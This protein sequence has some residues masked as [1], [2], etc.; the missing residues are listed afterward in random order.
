MKRR[1]VLFIRLS[2]FRI[3]IRK[4]VTALL[5]V[6]ALALMMLSK[7]DNVVLNKTAS[8]VASVFHPVLKVLQLPAELA[9]GGY[10]AV[11]DVILVYKQNKELKNENLKLLLL[12][13]QVRTLQAENSL[14]GEMLNYIPPPNAAYLTAK[15]VAEEGDGFA[16]SLIAYIGDTD[17]IKRGQVVLGDKSVVGRVDTVNGRYARII[18]ITDINSKI[19]VIVER[20]RSRGILSGD[21]TNF[22]KL[23]FAPLNAD[24]KIGDALVTSG[25]AGVFPSGLLLGTVARV[26]KDGIEIRTATDIEKLEYV[27]IVDY[28]IYDE[29]TSLIPEEKEQPHG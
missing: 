24:I 13:N 16:H 1:R 18:L 9:Y 10:S 23:L 11:R 25:V 17:K 7:A 29:T 8:A 14:L 6:S 19:P 26:G 20:S 22:P 4:F 12:Q 15:V 5:F 27:R 21:N 3:F 28:Q 2:Q